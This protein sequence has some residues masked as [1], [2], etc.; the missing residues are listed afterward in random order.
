TGPGRDHQPTSL[1]EPP[2]GSLVS[3]LNLAAYL[4][5]SIGYLL[6][7]LTPHDRLTLLPVTL[8][9]LINL[10]W[11][12]VFFRLNVSSTTT[13][14][15]FLVGM[16]LLAVGALL[17]FNLGLGYDWLLPTLTLAVCAMVLPWRSVVAIAALFLLTSA[18][19]IGLL[20]VQRGY[21]LGGDM[22]HSL[23]ET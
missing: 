17:C 11:L 5:L 21:P 1:R 20:D 3:L 4:S 9:T 19:V 23:L 7:L 15:P 18:G 6:A 13:I 16:V 12:W 2:G 22:L 14:A 8:F 10:G